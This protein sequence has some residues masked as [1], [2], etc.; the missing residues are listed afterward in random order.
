MYLLHLSIL[1][2]VLCWLGRKALTC[3]LSGGV[4]GYSLMN[5]FREL[6]EGEVAP[7]DEL[8]VVQVVLASRLA[9]ADEFMHPFVWICRSCC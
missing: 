9:S 7:E 6:S 5:E 1:T 8:G 3:A 4:V 2:I